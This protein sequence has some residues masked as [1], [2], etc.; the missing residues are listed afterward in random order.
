PFGGEIRPVP[1]V[2]KAARPAL[3]RLRRWEDTTMTNIPFPNPHDADALNN[4]LNDLAAGK[5]ATPESDVEMAA[6]EFHQLASRAE[7]GS[8]KQSVESKRGE[9]T[10]HTAPLA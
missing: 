6:Q 8:P 2:S 5:Q 4:Y 10:M 1:R 9:V 7:V 3:K